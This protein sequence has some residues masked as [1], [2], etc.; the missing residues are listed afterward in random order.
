MK[1]KSKSFPDY[2][3][4]RQWALYGYLPKEGATGIKLWANPYY[5]NSYTYY[6][7]DEVEKATDDQIN[8]ILA[9]E[10]ERRKQ[11]SKE[12]RER[13]KEVQQEAREKAD[14]E[15]QQTLADAIT[16]QYQKKIAELHRIIREM[17]NQNKPYCSEGKFYVIDT[18]TTGLDPERDELLQLSIISDNGEVVFNSY[19]RPCAK[20]W[21]ESQQINHISPDMVKN[22]LPFVDKR[23]EIN[24]I[25][26]RADTII[27]YN[28]Q[29]DI[30]FLENNGIIFP[31]NVKVVDV[32]REFA[33]I[34]G[35]WNEYYNEFRCKKL[36][37]AAEYYG[38][39]WKCRPE[40]AH[41][42]LADCF[43]TLFV[44]KRIN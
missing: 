16:A 32:A 28:T 11:Q 23:E 20:S 2:K 12:Y 18:E 25:L 39:D 3:T 8:T 38:Y 29:F 31:D 26:R 10:R 22:A 44:Y 37:F 19:F 34:Y 6:S 27:G 4:L 13:Q 30:A 40:K 43:A 21:E 35:D 33:I 7:P 41:N 9:P 14:R 36:T 1:I 5:N 42:S 15:R 17:S 24:S